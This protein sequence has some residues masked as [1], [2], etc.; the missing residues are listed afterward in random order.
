MRVT[1]CPGH[2]L[3]RVDDIYRCRYCHLKR[4]A[5]SS[6]TRKVLVAF[7]T[8]LNYKE[9]GLALGLSRQSIYYHIKKLSLTLEI[10]GA[11]LHYVIMQ[12][13]RMY[14]HLEKQDE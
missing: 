14:L 10:A 11:P 3:E 12:A 7:M 4:P 13:D 9:V 1:R 8:G 6:F 2:M 5:I